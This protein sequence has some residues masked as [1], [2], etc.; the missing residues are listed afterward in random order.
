MIAYL[1]YRVPF[2]LPV[3]PRED[4]VCRV[5]LKAVLAPRALMSQITQ[6]TLNQPGLLKEAQ[7]ESVRRIR[8]SDRH[9]EFCHP[10]SPLVMHLAV[11]RMASRSPADSYRGS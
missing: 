11:C 3:V 2:T 7:R 5:F 8:P 4:N 6:R 1:L 9:M 10:R